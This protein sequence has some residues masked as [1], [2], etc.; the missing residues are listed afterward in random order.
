MKRNGGKSERDSSIQSRKGT[1]LDFTQNRFEFGPEHFNRVEIRTVR[2]QIQHGST[3]GFNGFPHAGNLVS[4]EI[5]HYNN[6]SFPKMRNQK[7]LHIGTKN[8]SIQGALE[9]AADHLPIQ[10]DRRNQRRASGRVQWRL[11]PYARLSFSTPVE[12]RKVSVYPAFIQKDQ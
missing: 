9:I 6:V 3:G 2:R 10:P 11:V 1:S 7:L 12:T 4:R 5:V 8:I